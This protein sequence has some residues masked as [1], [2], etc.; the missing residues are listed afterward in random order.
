MLS[1]QLQGKI[2][3]LRCKE[4][5]PEFSLFKRGRYFRSRG[6]AAN[7]LDKGKSPS[8]AKPTPRGY[9]GGDSKNRRGPPK[10]G[11]DGRSSDSP[12]LAGSGG[13]CMRTLALYAPV[14]R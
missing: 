8:R 12:L 11:R 10:R 9:T 4:P 2:E 13:L 6:T 5:V 7:T 3:T 14:E 1:R